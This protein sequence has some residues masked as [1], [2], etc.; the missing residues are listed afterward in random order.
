MLHARPRIVR[1]DHLERVRSYLV[2]ALHSGRLRPGDRVPSVRRMAALT[3]M[4]RKTAHRAYVKL[5]R[6]GLL[7]LRVGSGTYLAE[8]KAGPSRPVPTSDLLGAANRSRAEAARLGLTPTAFARFVLA[9]LGDGLKGWPLA[10]TECNREQIELFALEIRTAL[11]VRCR[12]V[13][14]QDLEVRSR[15]AVTDCRGIVSTDFHRDEVAKAAAPLGLPVYRI[16]LEPA[17]PR[18]LVEHARRGP[19]VLV[20]LDRSF[21]PGFFRFM[22]D[23]GVDKEVMARVTVVE[24]RE[25]RSAFRRLADDGAVYLSPLVEEAMAGKVP[26]HL[27]RCR[28]PRHVSAASMERLRVR[29]ALDISLG[30]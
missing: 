28:I 11:G 14:V 13:L 1:R 30:S 15:E 24:P 25:A 10:V 5:A 4:D 19:V 3:G 20:V 9:A 22:T 7:D 23:S 21:A 27:R 17:F 26:P 29:L 2:A 16:A 8:V 12:P 18:T 6:E